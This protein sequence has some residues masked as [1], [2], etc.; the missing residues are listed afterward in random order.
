MCS[1]VVPIEGS[2]DSSMKSTPPAVPAGVDPDELMAE[3]AVQAAGDPLDDI[4]RQVVGGYFVLTDGQGSV[5]KWSEPAELLFAQSAE[6]ILGHGFFETLIGGA[7]P[8]TR[9]PRSGS[10]TPI[11]A[12]RAGSPTS[13]TPPRSSRAC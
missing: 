9:R 1:G 10:L 6:D 4:L 5:S 7:P 13:T 11:R 2:V 8:P 12:S 3:A